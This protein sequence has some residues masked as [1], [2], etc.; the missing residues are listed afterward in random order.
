MQMNQ[1][2]FSLRSCRKLISNKAVFSRAYAVGQHLPSATTIKLR[3]ATDGSE[4]SMSDL[5]SNKK[6]AV[7]GIV[8]AFTPTCQQTHVPEYIKRSDELKKAGADEIYVVSVNDH[9]V[10][11][12]F[13]S[14]LNNDKKVKF[15][16]DPDGFFTTL[17]DQRLDLTAAGLGLRSNRYSMVVENGVIGYENVEDAPGDVSQ[18]N[19]DQIKEQLQTSWIKAYEQELIALSNAGEMEHC[20]RLANGLLSTGY[21]FTPDGYLAIIAAFANRGYANEAEIMI[22]QLEESLDH[23][24]DSSIANRVEQLRSKAA[25]TTPELDLRTFAELGLKKQDPERDHD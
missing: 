20:V 10:M 24:V 16:A 15:F 8:G 6:V 5:F 11:K 14:K 4:H 18:T 17:I 1:L 2:S 25:A 22:K 13:E 12:S 19:V 9:L 23:K 7:V 3:S 21:K